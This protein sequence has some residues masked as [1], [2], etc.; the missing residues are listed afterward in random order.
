MFEALHGA[1]FVRGG[2]SFLT[3]FTRFSLSHMQKT[4]V[5]GMPTFPRK[6]YYT[7]YKNIAVP[8]KNLRSLSQCI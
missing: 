2:Q 5:F 3:Q 1:I 6:N 7:I 4:W 8:R